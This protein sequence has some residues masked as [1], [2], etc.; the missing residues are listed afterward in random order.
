MSDE[1]CKQY[2]EKAQ[3]CIKGE[4][5]FKM[6]V[7]GFC[8]PHKIE[9]KLD[10]GID[11]ICE[12]VYGSRPTGVLFAVQVR[13]VTAEPKYKG[14]E[15]KKGF[16]GLE[17]F[18]I[19]HSNLKISNETLNYWKGLAIP[20]YLFVIVPKDSQTGCYYKRFTPVVTKRDN[21]GKLHFYKVNDGTEFFAF[22][23]ANKK[24]GG[25]GFSRDLYVDY[26]RWNYYKGSISYLNPRKIGLQ[27][28]PA[29]EEGVIFYDLFEDYHPQ[30]CST[31]QKTKL[32]LEKWCEGKKVNKIL[33]KKKRPMQRK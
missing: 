5:F 9:E 6:L 13:Y 24:I 20:S 18:S 8:L 1:N 16:N 10:L 4:S 15:D 14:I 28:Y 33:I 23:G 32:L 31:Y 3:K 30:I 26:M 21:P 19:S 11:F 7:A 2:T 12:W 25:F 22:R 29:K 27:Q 17:K